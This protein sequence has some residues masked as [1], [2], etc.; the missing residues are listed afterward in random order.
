MERIIS[1]ASL[2]A[3][4]KLKSFENGMLL[5]HVS[6]ND[7]DGYGATY[8]VNK[9]L[10]ER[11][12][13][14]DNTNYGEIIS[15]LTE[16][17]YGLNINLLITD[18]NLTMDEASFIDNNYNDWCVIDHHGTGQD[19]ADTYPSNYFLDTGSCGTLQTFDAFDALTD[20]KDLKLEEVCVL[21][22]AYDIY[23]TESPLFRKG[24]LLANYVKNNMFQFKE[25]THDYMNFLFNWIAPHILEYGVRDT[26]LIFQ[27]KFMTY[28]DRLNEFGQI[29]EDS[30]LIPS[31]VQVAMLHEPLIRNKITYENDKFVI[32]ENVSTG[33]TQ[34]VNELLF[35]KEYSD[36]VLINLSTKGAQCYVAFRDILGNASKFAV[37]AGGGGHKAAAGCSFKL[38]D[39]EKGLDKLINLISSE[40][41]I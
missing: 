8:V 35:N 22:N 3:A 18:I 1:K 29:I 9:S 39:G 19:V 2:R 13:I 36:K 7:M 23:L 12:I 21:I 25:L 33:I 26:E 31:N 16:I 41:V 32:F 37:R 40:E 10:P 6:H 28:L 38:K 24:M 27:S 30:E 11:L 4:E 17:G 5:V 15:K 34:Y 14:Q 20:S